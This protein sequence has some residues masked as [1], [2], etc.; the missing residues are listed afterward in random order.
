M[1]PCGLPIF[2]ILLC[3][4]VVPRLLWREGRGG[5]DVVSHRRAAGIQRTSSMTSSSGRATVADI[6]SEKFVDGI[7]LVLVY[8]VA[9]AQSQWGPGPGPGPSESPHES[10]SI[11]T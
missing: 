2:P 5:G 1:S 11:H 4:D 8:A 7:L 6:Q 10:A 9:P 3:V